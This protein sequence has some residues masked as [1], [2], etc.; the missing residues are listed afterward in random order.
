MAARLGRAL[1]WAIG[2]YILGAVA[3]YWL[4]MWLSSNG[5]DRALEAAMT[6]AFVGGPFCAV[7]GAIAALVAGGRAPRAGT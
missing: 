5:H 4:T 1:L 2:A 7:I 3:T 6:A